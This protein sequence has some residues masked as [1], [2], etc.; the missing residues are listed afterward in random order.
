M[1]HND[2]PF[3]ALTPEHLLDAL[4]ALGLDCDGSVL[5]L[6]SY[7]NRVFQVGIYDKPPVIAKFYRPERWSDAAIGEEHSFLAELAEREIPV[8][9]PL[10]INGHT[11]NTAGGFRIAIFPRRGGRAGRCL[12]PARSANVPKMDRLKRI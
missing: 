6:N 7:E 3:A 10:A 5:A 1:S 9:A 8:V 4:E 2:A 11:L 12:R